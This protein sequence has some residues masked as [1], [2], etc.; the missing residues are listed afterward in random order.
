MENDGE[1]EFEFY[2]AEQ[3]GMTRAQVLQMSNDEFLGWSI[4]YGRKAQKAEL[5]RG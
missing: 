2:L 5:A 1:T 3:L 4:Y